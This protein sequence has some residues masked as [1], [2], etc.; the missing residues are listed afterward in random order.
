MNEIVY[1][2]F[3]EPTDDGPLVNLEPLYGM[4]AGT[5]TMLKPL[6]RELPGGTFQVTYRFVYQP[7][8]GEGD[9]EANS[10]PREIVPFPETIEAAMPLDPSPLGHAIPSPAPPAPAPWPDGPIDAIAIDGR[11]LRRRGESGDA[12][13]GRTYTAVATSY[14]VFLMAAWPEVGACVVIDLPE[15]EGELREGWELVG[16]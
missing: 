16:D 6:R 9:S 15:G 4:P 8:G 11:R 3:D 2:R 13:A 5:V 1:P 14:G 12:D 7:E 10:R